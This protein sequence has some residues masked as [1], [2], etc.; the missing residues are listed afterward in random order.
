VIP[1]LNGRQINDT[2]LVT[3]HFGKQLHNCGLGRL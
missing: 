1:G 3:L 2:G